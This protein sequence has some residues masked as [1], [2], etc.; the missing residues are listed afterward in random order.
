MFN[1]IVIKDVVNGDTIYSYL[2]RYNFS[3]NYIR[4]LRKKEGYIKLNN[5]ISFT[6]AKIK[7]G[8]ILE[9][10][11]NPNTKSSIMQNIIPLDIVYEDDDIIIVNKPSGMPTIPSRL[12]LNFNLAGAITSYMQ[13]KDPNFVVRIVNRL[14]KETAGLVIVAK[15]SLASNLLNNTEIFKTYYA[16]CVGEV[17]KITIDSPIKTITDSN[18]INQQRRVIDPSGKTAITHVFPVLYDG[19]N[20]LCR[21]TIEHGRTHQIRVHLSSINHP[22]LGDSLYGEPSSVISHTALCCSELKF[23]NPITNCKISVKTPLP[24]DFISAFNAEISNI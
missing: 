21:I 9:L 1:K 15:H 14:D 22:L 2:K 13:G 17:P 6:N 16:I 10:F 4:H 12:H 24:K 7:D 5:N 11:K 18:G 23:V 3:E 20:T 8:D 19:E